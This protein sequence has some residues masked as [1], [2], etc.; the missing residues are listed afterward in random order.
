VKFPSFSSLPSLQFPKEK[1]EVMPQVV[2]GILL[3]TTAL[4]PL[5]VLPFGENFLIDSKVLFFLI[6]SI[7]AVGVWTLWSFARKTI[8]ITLSPFLLPT[9]LF[10]IGTL[11]SSFLNDT[12]PLVHFLGIGGVYLAMAVL[13]FLAP[14]LLSQKFSRLFPTIFV[15]STL[16][17]ALTSAAELLNAG[18]SVVFNSLLRLNL[19]NSPLFSLSGSPLIAFEVIVVALTGGVTLLFSG[20]NNLKPFYA[21]AS[22]ILLIGAVV[23]GRALAQQQ[24]FTHILPPFGASWSIATDTLKSVKSTVIGVGPENYQQMYLKFKPVWVNT[25]PIW[26]LQFNQ[27]SNM[28]LTLLVTHGLIGLFAWLILAGVVIQ[29]LRKTTTETRPFAVMM[30]AILVIELLLPPNP[31]LIALQAL[32]LVFWI[33]ADKSRLQDAQLHAFTVVLVKSDLEIKKIPKYAHVFVYMAT[34]ALALLLLFCAFQ[35]SVYGYSQFFMFRAGVAAQQN[36]VLSVYHLQQRALTASP[37]LDSYRRSYSN[38]NM[39]IAQVLAQKKDITDDEKQQVLT[40]VNQAIDQAKAASS[41]DPEN[42]LNWVMMARTYNNLVGVSEGADTLAGSA[43]TQALLLAPSDPVINLELGNLYLRIGQYPQAVLQLEKTAG[44]KPDWPN[45]FYNLANAYKLNKQFD[46]AGQAYEQTVS[47]LPAGDE[48]NKV[49]AEMETMQQ[50]SAAGATETTEN[51]TTPS[52]S[53]SPTPKPTPVV[54]PSPTSGAGVEQKLSPAEAA[55]AS[56][57]LQ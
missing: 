42:S 10:F 41:I 57:Q 26:N 35:L 44:L 8:Q 13:I 27:G 2:A 38:T 30:V 28:P 23:N 56:Q 20:K 19:P 55:S 16:F 40:L 52:V 43:Y 53:A 37:Y 7:L 48:A 31:V 46:A 1:I 12:Y 54:S 50:E 6:M 4:M 3:A 14:S 17:L 24:L 49:K 9:A 25:T 34:S 32:C 18:P 47:L 11:L 29:Q 36:D 51:N 45:A 39:V 22:V 5:L 15:V 21:L 33:V